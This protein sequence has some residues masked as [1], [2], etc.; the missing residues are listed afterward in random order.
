MRI[1]KSHAKFTYLFLWKTMLQSYILLWNVCSVLEC[2]FLFCPCDSIHCQ[3]TQQHF[4]SPGCQLMKTQRIAAMETRKQTGSE[5]ENS[6]QLK[7]LEKFKNLDDQRHV[8]IWI[9]IIEMCIWRSFHIRR[10]IYGR[11]VLK[12]ITQLNLLTFVSLFN[13]PKKHALKQAVMFAAL[14]RLRW[15]LWLCSHP[16]P[17]VLLWNLA[18]TLICPV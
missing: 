10:K 13:A 9:N 1:F 3:F 14:G 7:K 17:S 16:L 5:T 2:L 4:N 6:T 12:W 18:L 15:S 8:K 11:R